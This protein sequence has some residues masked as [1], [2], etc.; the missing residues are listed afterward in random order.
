MSVASRSPAP[1]RDV[2]ERG[3]L[4]F[5]CSPTAR[6][7][8]PR[9]FVVAARTVLLVE[10]P[11]PSVLILGYGLGL[12]GAL[13]SR[14]RP[15]ATIY[16]VER[17]RRLAAEARRHLPPNAELFTEDAVSYLERTRRR[18][19]LILDDC[20]VLRG[21][22]AIRPRELRGHADLVRRRLGAGGLYVR[23]LLP[24]GR[25]EAA[26]QVIDIRRHFAWLRL[27]RFRDWDNVLALA[28]GKAKS[29]ASLRRLE[30][31]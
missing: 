30:P 5:T 26:D 9:P 24:H 14:L 4:C 6:T 1:P 20:F 22:D 18:F 25:L 23:N 16:G 8:P 2:V 10:P 3:D 29:P 11:D 19:D 17:S 12:M 27:R 28:A 21:T 15:A 31:R 13:V 7:P